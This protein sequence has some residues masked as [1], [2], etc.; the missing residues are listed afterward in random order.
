MIHRI[1]HD[2]A[3]GRSRPP[4]NQWVGLAVLCLS[5]G[6]AACDLEVTN[7]GVLEDAYIDDPVN[8]PALIAGVRGSYTYAAAGPV[9]GYGVYLAGALLTDEAVHSGT[10]VGLR[11]FSDGI[12]REEW[13]EVHELWA[14]ASRARWTAEDLVRRLDRQIARAAPEDTG[15]IAEL[16][17]H[18]L[19]ALI[20]AGFSGRLLGENFCEAVIDKG[21]SQPHTVFFE[22][23]EAHFTRAIQLATEQG[24]EEFLLV[25]HAGRAQV[26]VGLGRWQDAV[27]DAALVPT[28]FVF[29][30]AHYYP[31]DRETNGFRSA[32]LPAN[33]VFTVWGTPFADWGATGGDPRVRY[34]MPTSGGSPVIGLDQRRPFWQ[35]TKYSASAAPI[36]VATG[37]EMRLIEAE[38]AL[39][40]GDVPGAV[41]AIQLV[42]DYRNAPPSNMGLPPAAAADANEAWTLL[43]R[44]RGIEL[45]LEGRRLGDIRRWAVSPGSVP[46]DVVRE[47]GSGGPDTDARRNVLQTS[48]D[49]CIP[50]SRQERLANPNL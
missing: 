17:E 2:R 29:T 44:E 47:A 35:Q 19:E 12:A 22:R 39:R 43:M 21:P 46:F 49:L 1:V 42:R 33:P 7:P 4:I 10:E 20:W 31:S 11:G 27:A 15:T 38:A 28:E 13:Q 3:G 25:A 23:A 37:V 6:L 41:A 50:I 45:W 36:E 34:T 48:G 24:S 9:G 18:L 26:R 40:A 32:S 16:E 14:E 8:L 5:L 30:Q